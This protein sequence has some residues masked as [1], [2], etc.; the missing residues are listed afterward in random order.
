MAINAEQNQLQKSTQNKDNSEQPTQAGGQTMSGSGGAS[1]PQA[2]T[3]SFSTGSQPTQGS[4]RFTNLKSYI[5]ANQGAGDRLA[6]G[7]NKNVNQQTSAK[8]D[9]ANT[10]AGSVRAGIEGAQTKLGTGTDY[11]NQ[12][13]NEGFNAQEF[14]ADQNKLND[15]GQFRTNQAIDSQGLQSGVGGAQQAAAT[16]QNA[17]QNYGNQAAT[18][19]GRFG[20]LKNTFGGQT[21]YANPYSAG[22]QRLDQLFLQSGG[23]NGVK[24]LQDNIRGNQSEANKLAGQIDQYGNQVTDITGQ[25]S[26]LAQNLQNRTNALETGYI[27]DLEGQVAGVNAGRAADQTNYKNFFNTLTGKDPSNPLNQGLLDESGLKRGQQ[28]FN[29]LNDPNLTAENVIKFDPRSASGYQDIASQSN[30]NYYDALSKLAGIDNS[31][32]NSVGQLIDPT[33]GGIAKGASFLQGE[34]GLSGRVGAARDR[35]L[36]D[37]ANFSGEGSR[38]QN[39]YNTGRTLTNPTS[40]QIGNGM[41]GVGSNTIGATAGSSVAD[42]LRNLQGNTGFYQTGTKGDQFINN[43]VG[44]VDDAAARLFAQNRG[45]AYQAG[46]DATTS[47]N[48]A[49]TAAQNAQNQAQNSLREQML[50]YLGNQGFYNYIGDNGATT[51]DRDIAAYGY[52]GDNKDNPTGIYTPKNDVSKF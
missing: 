40:S 32:L 49:R 48:S 11:L 39:M 34:E 52:G 27:T 16:Y 47:L 51:G 30:V 33:T 4:G 46:Q 13:N 20:L 23:T 29:V 21:T 26:T 19:A 42:Y 1:G 41:D 28:T 7:I 37:A 18:E 14:A 15:F 12:V 38:F 22:Q 36:S 44:N 8:K 31:K 35:I 43:N 2:R 9:D 24:Q 10:Q 25:A 3:A 5:N 45:D 6:Q 50:N 17:L